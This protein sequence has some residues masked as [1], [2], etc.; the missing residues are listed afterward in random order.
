MFD[1]LQC[2]FM[3]IGTICVAVAVIPY[4]LILI[5]PMA[6]IF[7][8]LRRYFITA[9]R[10]VKRLE[11]TT[12][13]PVYSMFSSTL[14]GLAII[15]AFGMEKPFFKNF[16]RCQNE[17]TRIFFAFL[18]SSRWLGLRLDLM[19]AAFLVIIAFGSIALRGV[20][21]RGPGL[22]G[23]MLSYCLQLLGLIQWAV[24]QSA[25]VE[26]LM[27]SAERCLEYCKLP[28]EPPEITDVRPPEDWPSK[29]HVNL[30]KMSL[31]YPGS[32]NP[33]LKS[34]SIDIAGGK[35][36]GVVGRTGAGKSSI[37]QALFRL[38]DPDPPGSITIDG[39]DTSKLGLFDLR[40][41]LSIIPQDPFCFKGTLRFNI[42]PFNRYSDDQIWQAL[43]AVELKSVVS[44]LP[45]KLDAAVTENGG[46]WSFGERQLICL[47]S[48]FNL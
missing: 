48:I 41:R 8:F 7:Y 30:S 22:V 14:E 31:T 45:E 40:S 3:V 32:N 12:R 26:N 29:G 10:K 42:D 39:I 17:N 43:E 34:I 36:I 15:R 5:P 16:I 21:D 9:S 23:L 4:V 19:A 20:F 46:N 11:A 28:S 47:V 38:V 2:F 44:G 35:K 25:E 33:V 24:R 18:S 13:S 37:F 1:F 6:F 27:V